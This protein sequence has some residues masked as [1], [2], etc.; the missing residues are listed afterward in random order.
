[1]RIRRYRV[2]LLFCALMPA[3]VGVAQDDDMMDFFDEVEEEA[4]PP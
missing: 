3:M 2:L 1:M 4:R